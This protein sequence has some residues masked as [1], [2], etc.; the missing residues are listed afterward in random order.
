MSSQ[1]RHYFL[2]FA[3]FK[4]HFLPHDLSQEYKAV[5]DLNTNKI[6]NS[7]L[8]DIKLHILKDIE[9]NFPN[10]SVKNLQL[11]SLSYL[12]EMTPE[13]FNT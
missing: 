10:I 4:D 9:T 13:E 7:I 2:T 5:V 1:K 8:E 11:N 6:T 3:T 12:G